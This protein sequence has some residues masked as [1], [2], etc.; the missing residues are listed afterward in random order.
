MV[1]WAFS[2]SSQKSGCAVSFSSCAIFCCFPVTSKM[3]H[4]RRDPAL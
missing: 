2:W 3:L 1:R 4:Y